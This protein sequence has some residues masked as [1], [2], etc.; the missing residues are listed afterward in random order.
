MTNSKEDVEKTEAWVSRREVAYAWGWDEGGKL[1]RWFGVRGIPH[2]VL[3]DP[4]GTIVWRGHPAG[5]DEKT[6]RAATSAA[7]RTPMWTWPEGSQGVKQAFLK[8]QLGKAHDAAVKLG[9]EAVLAAI[10]GLIDG[11]ITAIE[12]AREEGDFLRA[13]GL[14]EAAKK[15][16]AGL[17]QQERAEAILAEIKK[18]K[19]AA[20]VVKG[21]KVFARLA[22][23]AAEL[24]K[25]KDGKKL[26]DE[27]KKLRKKYPDTIIEKHADELIS[28]LQR[29]IPTLK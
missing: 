18:D 13:I 9:D 3:V 17:P 12:G 26:L 11:R 7:L 25:K 22:E 15:E 8:G 23:R 5:L 29:K 10:T 19:T 24:E 4:T 16:L 1:S 28:A 27:L 20:E 14:A 6:L 2:A 21:Q